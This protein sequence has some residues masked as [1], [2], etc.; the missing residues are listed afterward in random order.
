MGKVLVALLAT[1]AGLWLVCLVVGPQIGG[2]AFSV[3]HFGWNVTWTMV[4]GACLG[5]L[6][7][8]LV[9]GK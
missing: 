7:Y 9:K 8:K 2:H 4:V 1:I 6:F 5:G 3:P